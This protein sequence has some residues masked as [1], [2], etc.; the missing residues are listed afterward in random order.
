M[1]TNSERPWSLEDFVLG[2]ALGKVTLI[3]VAFIEYSPVAA[4]DGCSLTHPVLTKTL[5]DIIRS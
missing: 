4:S 1:Q 5:L 3:L 2:K